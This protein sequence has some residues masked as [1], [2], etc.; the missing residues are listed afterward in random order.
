MK[1]IVIQIALLLFCVYANA[2]DAITNNGN[3]QIHTGAS[4]G[5]VWKFYQYFIWSITEQRQ[6]FY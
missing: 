6:P 3:L 1:K 5:G 2:Q 4:I